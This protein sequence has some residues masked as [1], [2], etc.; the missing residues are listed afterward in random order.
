MSILKSKIE[1]NSKY[2]SVSPIIRVNF[3][4]WHSIFSYM[5]INA[6]ATTEIVF[7]TLS[8][9]KNKKQVGKHSCMPPE[10]STAIHYAAPALYQHCSGLLLPGNLLNILDQSS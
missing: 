1:C 3:V 7:L 5:G 4:L 10:Q 9:S 8:D 2:Q 6:C